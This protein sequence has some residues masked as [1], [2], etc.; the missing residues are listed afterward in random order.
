MTIEQTIEIPENHRLFFD[1]P[2]NIPSGRAKVALT[3]T[4]EQPPKGDWR[5]L[6]GKYKDSRT[7]ADFNEDRAWDNL[8]EEVRMADR[9]GRAIPQQVLDSARRH[10]FT[11]EELRN[12]TYR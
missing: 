1:I 2:W 4:P 3:V 11:I 8:I 7:V 6:C 10:G 9:N 12:G 5:S